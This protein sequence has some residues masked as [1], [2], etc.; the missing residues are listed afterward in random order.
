MEICTEASSASWPR[1]EVRRATETPLRGRGREATAPQLQGSEIHLKL[2]ELVCQDFPL[3]SEVL[4]S[5]WARAEGRDGK[6][7]GVLAFLQGT[8]RR[9]LQY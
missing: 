6:T 3:G 8:H 1:L 2:S 9:Q 5:S 7:A 4:C